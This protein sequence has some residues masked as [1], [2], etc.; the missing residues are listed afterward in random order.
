MKWVLMMLVYWNLFI[1]EL[2]WVLVI[3][4]SDCLFLEVKYI[5]TEMFVLNYFYDI[6]FF[7]CL[8]LFG[9]LK[10]TIL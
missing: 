7:I 9:F 2:R 1:Q 10:N 3:Y 8:S 5:K 6:V 4:Y